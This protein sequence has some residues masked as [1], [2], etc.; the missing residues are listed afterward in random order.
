MALCQHIDEWLLFYFQD[1]HKH[2]RLKEESLKNRDDVEKLQDLERLGNLITERGDDAK[3]MQAER[4][5]IFE[6]EK[7]D[8]EGIIQVVEKTLPL[9]GSIKP[10]PF[11]AFWVAEN[12]VINA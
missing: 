10:I 2:E 9:D 1:Y 11:K 7:Y 5:K 4:Q 12:R 6:T 3:L 8:L